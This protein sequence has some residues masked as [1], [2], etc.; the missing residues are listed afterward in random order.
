MQSTKELAFDYFGRFPAYSD[1]Y[2]RN[3]AKGVDGQSF[4]KEIRC[5]I[6]GFGHPLSRNQEQRWGYPGRLHGGPSFWASYL[7]E[8]H[9]RLM[10]FF[11]ILYW[12]NHYQ[13]RPQKT[14][15]A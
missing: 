2:F 14:D 4:A 10:R 1:S 11:R 8:V 6:D 12:Q 3:R 9:G 5:V 13:P 7:C 15:K